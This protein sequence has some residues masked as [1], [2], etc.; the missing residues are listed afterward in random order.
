M[1]EE[2][3]YVPVCQGLIKPIT[4][5]GVSREA[6]ILN[7]TLATVFIFSLKLWYMFPVFIVSH[8]LL[9]RACKKDPE[10]I[11]IFQ[12]KY[13]RQPDYFSEG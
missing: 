5:M 10:V 12:K 1:E 6:M 11:N 8:Y 2:G 7:G 13:V 3:F 4:I 9:Y